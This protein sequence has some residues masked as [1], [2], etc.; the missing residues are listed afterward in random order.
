MNAIQ[1]LLNCRTPGQC[2]ET[3]VKFLIALLINILIIRFLWNTALVKHI[4]VLKPAS[5]LLD[6]LLLAVS[7]SLVL[8]I[9][10]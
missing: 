5:T 8:G 6:T 4:T 7:M 3:L 2:V 10:K 1:N 9:P